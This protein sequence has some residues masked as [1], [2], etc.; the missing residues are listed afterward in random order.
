MQMSGFT[1]GLSLSEEDKKEFQ[2]MRFEV[3]VKRDLHELLIAGASDYH[4]ISD[5]DLLAY[6]KGAAHRYGRL[7]A[8]IS[9]ADIVVNGDERA[10]RYQREIFLYR[11]VI[12]RIQRE[13]ARRAK[14]RY[15]ADPFPHAVDY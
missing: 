1:M 12:F 4:K 15:A 8:L 14:A 2:M 11:Q 3:L 10:A 5:D 9:L 6:V 13:L 7:P